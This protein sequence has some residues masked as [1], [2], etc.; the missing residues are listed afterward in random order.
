[1]T[2]G[3]ACRTAA[4]N[5]SLPYIDACCMWCFD[6][7]DKFDRLLGY[8]SYPQGHD[9]GAIIRARIQSGRQLC[10]NRRQHG[11]TTD[12]NLEDYIHA[13]PCVPPW[14][15]NEI[16]RLKSVGAESEWEVESAI[17]QEEIDRSARL[18]HT[19]AKVYQAELDGFSPNPRSPTSI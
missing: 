9:V 13:L 1:M 4:V 2:F 12:V 14:D 11:D 19:M 5:Q 7:A 15:A 18:A 10:A 16:A 6:L 3:I 8:P 17:M